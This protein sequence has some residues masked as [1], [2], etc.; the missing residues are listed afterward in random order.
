MLLSKTGLVMDW[1]SHPP[2]ILWKSSELDFIFLLIFSPCTMRNI[3]HKKFPAA[4]SG[5]WWVETNREVEVEVDTTAYSHCT[6][7]GDAS[8]VVRLVLYSEK[9][10]EKETWSTFPLSFPPS[11]FPFFFPSFQSLFLSSFFLSSFLPFFC[12]FFPSYLLSLPPSF[13]SLFPTFFLSS[14]HPSSLP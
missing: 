12:P 11:V 7:D 14:I 6:V 3:A 5:L 13:L 10:L 2:T 1:S 4:G 9:K 8:T